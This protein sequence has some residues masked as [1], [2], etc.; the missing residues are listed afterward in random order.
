MENTEII[1]QR[2]E[3]LTPW[4]KGA[5]TEQQGAVWISMK[6]RKIL[7]QFSKGAGEIASEKLN[8]EFKFLAPLNLNEHIVH[9]W[10]AYESVA[11][12]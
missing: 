12:D 1:Y 9:H 8:E 10:E 4:A 3:G 11:L 5:G 2:P 6:P 7:D